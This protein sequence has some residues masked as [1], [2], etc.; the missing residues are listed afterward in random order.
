MDVFL[1]KN[2]WNLQSSEEEAYETM[3]QLA[4]GNLTKPDLSIW[5]NSRSSKM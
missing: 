5:L 4:S 3:I 1:Q 2:G